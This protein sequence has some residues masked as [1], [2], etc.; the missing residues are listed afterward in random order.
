MGGWLGYASLDQEE[1]PTRCYRCGNELGMGKAEMLAVDPRQAS[2]PD[3]LRFSLY[4]L[5][6]LRHELAMR[7]AFGRQDYCQRCWKG[8]DWKYDLPFSEDRPA[9]EDALGAAF[10]PRLLADAP[11]AVYGLKGN[12]L[13][14]RLTDL[15]RSGP[16]RVILRYTS[17]GPDSPQRALDLTQDADP[18]PETREERGMSELRAVISLVMG[19]AP[20]EQRERYRSRRNVHRHWNLYYLSRAPRRNVTIRIDGEAVSVEL[21]HWQ[22]P[23]QVVLAR[24]APGGVSLMAVSLGVSQVQLLGALKSLAALRRDADAL[25]QHERDYRAN[26][27]G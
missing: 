1:P 17:G 9:S 2:S 24:L 8:S 5:N 12:P 22:E 11:F 23:H 15:H 25:A 6:E 13:E 21:A 7:W 10:L 16:G 19:C 18:S 3:L 4:Y 14:L 20:P 27:H 26:L